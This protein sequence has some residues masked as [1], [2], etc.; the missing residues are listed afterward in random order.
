MQL[1][2]DTLR[3]LA[4]RTYKTNGFVQIELTSLESGLAEKL[5]A[6]YMEISDTPP[7]HAPFTARVGEGFFQDISPSLLCKRPDGSYQ[8]TWGTPDEWLEVKLDEVEFDVVDGSNSVPE[9]VAYI[10]GHPEVTFKVYREDISKFSV[11]NIEQNIGTLKQAERKLKMKDLEIGATYQLVSY[12]QDTYGYTMTL[13]P[14]NSDKDIKAY[15]NTALTI[16]LRMGT[17]KEGDSFTVL[18]HDECPKGTMVR[19]GIR[20]V[21]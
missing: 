20:P 19:V 10:K 21:A 13:R 7:I 3:E 18:G 15:S 5:I 2:T 11:K 8:I 4:S 16:C 9:V 14:P 17:L 1:S 6:A 12:F